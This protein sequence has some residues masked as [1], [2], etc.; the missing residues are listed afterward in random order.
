METLE[1]KAIRFVCE[2]YEY[3][4]VGKKADDVR[5]KRRGYDVESKDRKIEVKATKANIPNKAGL[6][7]TLLPKQYKTLRKHSDYWIYRVYNVDG[8]GKPKVIPIP[9]NM[10]LKHLDSYIVHKLV[11]KKTEWEQLEKKETH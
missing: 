5:S 3:E 11:L 1:D 9:R 6:H 7:V 10:I 2:Q 4:R 8:E